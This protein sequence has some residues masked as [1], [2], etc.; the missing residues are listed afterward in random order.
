LHPLRIT[1]TA[2]DN[3]A[4]DDNCDCKHSVI[5][6]DGAESL[7]DLLKRINAADDGLALPGE[8]PTFGG[9][10]PPDDLNILSWDPK[11]LLVGTWGGDGSDCEIVSRARWAA[12]KA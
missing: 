4:N 12:E 11:R 5:D 1:T 2:E 3:M 7:D 10:E 6:L 9:E 8:W